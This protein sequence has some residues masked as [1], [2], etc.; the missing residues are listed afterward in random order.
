MIDIQ[1]LLH[2]MCFLQGEAVLLYLLQV[3]YITV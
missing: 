2:V 3:I 1:N